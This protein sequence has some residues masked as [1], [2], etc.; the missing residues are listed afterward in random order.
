[1]SEHQITSSQFVEQFK[2]LFIQ[3]QKL[4]KQIKHLDMA[5]SLQ[6]DPRLSYF[7]RHIFDELMHDQPTSHPIVRDDLTGLLLRSTFLHYLEITL[8][9]SNLRTN[10]LAVCFIDLDG[11]KEINDQ[12]G[13]AV[14]DQ[15]LG[16]VGACLAN[17]IRSGDLLCRWGGDEFVVVFRDI[18][19]EESVASLAN[20]L[21]QAL[22]NPFRLKTNESLT[23]F[24]TASIGICI[25]KSVESRMSTNAL[26]IIEDAD[27]AMYCAKKA[28]KNR[29]MYSVRK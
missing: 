16:M 23:L 8:K 14:G 6:V 12:H 4:T 21:H 19:R 24:L 5:A 11:F 13:H 9:E 29:I 7:E 17:S 3:L 22:S 1:M 27:R 20:R 15:A 18:D 25:A 26:A 28:G 2:T 10:F